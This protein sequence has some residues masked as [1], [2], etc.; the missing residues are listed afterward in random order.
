[1]MDGVR[2]G[3][4]VNGAIDVL[5]LGDHDPLGSGEML[6][7]VTGDGLLLLSSEGGGTLM[8]PNLI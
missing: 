5:F 7:Q 4:S 8:H 3:V 1:M 6:F 2:V